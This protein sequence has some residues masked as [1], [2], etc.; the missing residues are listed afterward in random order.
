M[1]FADVAAAA[2]L[3]CLDYVDE[4]PWDEFASAKTWYTRMK[5][6]R[7]FRPLLADRVPGAAPAPQYANLD[8]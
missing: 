2:Q 7:S 6:R 8:F 4:V 1:S 5:S 3:S